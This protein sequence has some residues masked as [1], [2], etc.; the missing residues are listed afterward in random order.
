MKD[1]NYKIS[2]YAAPIAFI[3]NSLLSPMSQT[4]D[5]GI[6]PEFWKGFPDFSDD[7]VADALSSCASYARAAQRKR[8]EGANPVQ[9]VSVEYT[10]LF[11]G[12][13]KPAAP[14]WETAYQSHGDYVGF[15]K[16]TFQM[17]DLM[18]EAGVRIGD[19]RNQY[20]DHMGIELLLLSE[21]CSSEG[22][23]FAKI[24]HYV[25]EHPLSWIA[26]FAQRVQDTCPNGYY[27][28][29]LR[30]AEAVLESLVGLLRSR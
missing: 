28:M 4:A 16:P 6:D 7:R 15:G 14:P 11:I 1:N 10:M 13:P 26:G 23:D 21:Y 5:A 8:L 27:A 25:E 24:A 30:L 18:R 22:V 29:L 17:R 2:D 19:V 9:D 12:P 20:E 3:G